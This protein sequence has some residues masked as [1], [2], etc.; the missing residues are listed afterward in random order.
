MQKSRSSLTLVILIIAIIVF[1]QAFEDKAFGWGVMGPFKTHQHILNEAYK[2]LQADP[3]FDP[4]KFPSLEPILSH[5]GVS[6]FE[7]KFTGEGSTGLDASLI[8]GP[9]PDSKGNSPFSWHYYNP[10]TKEGK[11]PEA[12]QKYYRYLVQGMLKSQREVLPKSAAWS[13]HFLSDMHCPYHI[14]GSNRETIVAIKDKQLAENQG[15]L[16]QGAV[17]LDDVIKGSVKL[18]YLMVTPIKSMSNNFRTEIDRF[19]D[20]D[21]DWFDPWYYNG[22]YFNK[23]ISNT[24]SHIL[25]EAT[26]NPVDYNL[27]GYAPGWL[28]ANG[29]ID[30]V[31][32][33]QEHQTY[34]LAVKAALHAREQLNEL[35]NYPAPAVNEAIR[36][37]YSMWR[38]SFSAMRLDIDI[39]KDGEFLVATGIITNKGNAAL[40]KVEVRLNSAKCE[41]VSEKKSQE[42]GELQP[43]IKISTQPWRIKTS[44]EPC[45]LTMDAVCSSPIP[46]LQY[47][48]VQYTL[49]P[50][51]TL[52]ISPVKIQLTKKDKQ[53]FKALLQ[54]KETT[55]VTWNVKEGS[56]GGS[57]TDAGIYSPGANGGAFTILATSKSDTKLQAEAAVII[58]GISLDTTIINSVPNNPIT[59]K[60]IVI[61]PPEKPKFEWNF[62]DGSTTVTTDAKT[63]THTYASQGAYKIVIKMIDSVSGNIIDEANGNVNIEENKLMDGLQTCRTYCDKEKTKIRTEYTYYNKDGQELRHGKYISYHCN[64]QLAFKGQYRDGNCIGLHEGFDEAGKRLEIAN[65]DLKTREEF[66]YYGNNQLKAH[67]RKKE[68]KEHG[69]QERFYMSGTKESEVEYQEGIRSGKTISWGENGKISSKGNYKIIRSTD[70]LLKSVQDGIFIYYNKSG[71]P[72]LEE[73]FVDDSRTGR[74]KKYYENGKLME[75]GEYKDYKEVGGWKYYYES[76]AK[77]RQETGRRKNGNIIEFDGVIEWDE[78]GNVTFK[79][80]I[81]K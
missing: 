4:L 78:K 41:I 79:S 62:G 67:T 31:V 66:T 43:G 29:S 68:G 23:L 22:D 75:E 25:W 49:T 32:T 46:D 9:G 5:E 18:S 65:C 56:K 70:G 27:Q 45:Q 60:L 77:K 44:E 61:S 80:G 72:L 35:F 15:T 24:S 37:V 48:R 28:N 39:K 6:P 64:G 13:A 52:K 11:G 69:L 36:S 7:I 47:A 58:S 21:N 59:F 10:Y 55:D 54:G 12:V 57:I 16:S 50:E 17:Y 20:T 73:T 26:V 30:K 8:A 71:Q 14:N 42:L 1:M 81:Y 38:A 19:I 3:A 34:N 40:Q 63:S 76:G 51:L 74:H 53:P 2:L 33:A